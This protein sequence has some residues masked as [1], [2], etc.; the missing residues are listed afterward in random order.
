MDENVRAAAEYL[1]REYVGRHG[2]WAIGIAPKHVIIYTK[3][4]KAVENLPTE[5]M[6]VPCQIQVVKA[7]VEG[8][9]YR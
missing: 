1:N 9:I 4:K 7:P 3:H 8:P 5:A 2:V 6:G